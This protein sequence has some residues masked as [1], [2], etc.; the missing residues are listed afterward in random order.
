MAEP[1]SYLLFD[2]E[3]IER[4]IGMGRADGE[5]AW[6]HGWLSDRLP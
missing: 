1:Q 6:R 5:V 3:F 4:L 2:T